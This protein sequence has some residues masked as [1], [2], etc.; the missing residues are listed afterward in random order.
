M[1]KIG[2]KPVVI[3]SGVTV[4]FADNTMTVKGPKGELKQTVVE[5]VT[6]AIEAT[7]ATVAV[8]SV[9]MWKYWGL[10][11][12]LLANMIEGVTNM[13]EKK[14]QLL[15]VGY[16]AALKGKDLELTIGFSHKVDV[17]TPANITVAVEKDAKGNSIITCTSIDKQ[18]VG[19]FAS[20][21]RALRK[22]EPYKG[23]GIRY[24]GEFVKLKPGKAAK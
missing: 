19:E 20:K 24:F 7:E 17:K 2:K 10:Y 9:D 4:S 21:V 12:T 11:R 14:L 23:K 3:P 13:Y 8:P 6:V 15:G 22:P 5:G 18:A 16:N 1:S